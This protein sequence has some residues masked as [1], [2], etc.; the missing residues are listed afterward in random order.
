MTGPNEIQDGL[1]RNPAFLLAQTARLMRERVSGALRGTGLSPQ[2]LTIL[3]LLQGSGPINQ[4][5]LGT[6][7]NLDK[8]TI[9]ELIDS[10]QAAG[11]VRRD[12][13]V[14]DRR[15]KQIS[16]TVSGKRVLKKASRLAESVEKEFVQLLSEREWSTVQKCLQRYLDESERS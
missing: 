6:A 5:E 15:A 13:N 8:T 14:N 7:C 4:Q 1:R 10:L 9:T 16:I 3:R 2:E 11:F 12:V